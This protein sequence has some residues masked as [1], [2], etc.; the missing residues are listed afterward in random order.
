M[1]R[2]LL[3][4]DHP[5]YREGVRRVIEK[6]P[7]VELVGETA[8]A[9]DAP[10]LARQQ[11]ADVLLLDV[12]MPG[13]GYLATIQAVKEAAPDTKVLVV[14]G[15]DELEYAVPAL[16]AGAHGYVM[17]SFQPMELIEAIRRVNAG[18]RYVSADLADQLAGGLGEE[19]GDQP[20]HYRLSARE[21]EVLTLMASGKS[22]KEIAAELDINAKT[23]SSYRARILEKLDAASNAD[24]VRY[25]L[26]HDLVQR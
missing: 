25:A 26:E 16:K 2:V 21:L 3:A 4:D 20:P 11:K 7:E 14:S 1:I 12:T 8:T 22:L 13:P 17:K 24:L 6:I 18:R 5:I 23:V 9:A 15:H 10:L 19:A